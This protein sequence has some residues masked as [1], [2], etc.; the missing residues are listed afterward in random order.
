MGSKKWVF[1]YQNQLNDYV[2]V[3]SVHKHILESSLKVLCIGD[4]LFWL[5]SVIGFMQFIPSVPVA[6]VLA[7]EET[8]QVC[9]GGVVNCLLIKQCKLEAQILCK[10]FNLSADFLIFW[11]TN[12]SWKHTGFVWKGVHK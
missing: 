6:E 11:K 1:S 7:T 4:F 5:F 2:L 8:I 3:L 9:D 12:Y 10:I